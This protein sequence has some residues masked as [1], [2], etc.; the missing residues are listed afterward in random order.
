[1]K[2]KSYGLTIQMKRLC[3]NFHNV[4]SSFQKFTAWSSE[5]FPQFL[6]FANSASGLVYTEIVQFR[7]HYPRA[8]TYADFVIVN[9]YFSLEA[10]TELCTKIFIL[11]LSML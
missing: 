10:K 7:V 2:V 11:I 6:T 8:K 9:P 5:C 4:L 1:M 3:Q